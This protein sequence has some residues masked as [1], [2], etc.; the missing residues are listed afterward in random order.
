[1]RGVVP[2]CRSL[3]AMSIFA[4]TAED[5]ARVAAVAVKFDAADAWSRSR[6]AAGARAAGAERATFRFARAASAA[7]RILRQRRLCAV[8]RC[9]RAAPART[10]RRS[11]AKS[12]SSRCSKPRACCTKVRGWP[13]DTS[14]PSR[15]WPRSPEA[16]L[17]VTR[18]HHLRWRQSPQAL[19]AFR[20]QYRLK[21]LIRQAQPIWETAR[22]AAAAAPPALTTASTTSRPNPIRLNSTLGSLHQL[23]ESHGS[24]GRRGACGLYPG[25]ICLSAC[26]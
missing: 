19:D 7:A 3:D 18:Q 25:T 14:P 24:R 17:D 21:D 8:V 2:A 15:C 10:R 22:A 9:Q 26:R 1:M 12:T 16:M 23:R 11:D 20:A 4:L 13:S 6:A 5:A